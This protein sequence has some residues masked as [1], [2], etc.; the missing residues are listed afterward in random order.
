M[1]IPEND[2]KEVI[3]AG[4]KLICPICNH[5]RFW[6]RKTQMNTRA[7]TFL[8]LDWLNRNATNYVCGNCGYIFWFFESER[9]YHPND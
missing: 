8:K 6:S 5:R 2:E 3:K 4:H 9:G 1:L 7:A